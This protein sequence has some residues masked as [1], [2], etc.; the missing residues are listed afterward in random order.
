ME[1]LERLF[2]LREKA[3]RLRGRRDAP[4]AL[5][6]LNGDPMHIP[7]A[8]Q[9]GPVLAV[10]AVLAVALSR[11]VTL[12]QAALVVVTVLHRVLL[13]VRP[14]VVVFYHTA[15]GRNRINSGLPTSHLPLELLGGSRGQ[16][17]C[18][19]G[20]WGISPLPQHPQGTLVTS[21]QVDMQQSPVVVGSSQGLPGAPVPAEIPSRDTVGLRP[22][23]PHRVQP[24]HHWEPLLAL[25]KCWG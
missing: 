14:V 2:S 11:A 18:S 13:P 21:L 15:K 20:R 6:S 17:Q 16:L 24:Q 19:S 23:S 3:D 9:A 12:Q 10:A 8:G 25:L 4:L 5:V 1:L 7:A 22:P